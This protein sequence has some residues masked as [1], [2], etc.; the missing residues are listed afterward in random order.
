MGGKTSK[1]ELNKDLKKIG[2]EANRKNPDSLESGNVLIYLNELIAINSSSEPEKDYKIIKL[3]KK[4]KF[5]DINLV[6][7]KISG[8]KGIMKTLHKAKYFSDNDE[9]FLKALTS[10]DHPNIINIFSFY[11][12]ENSYS[13][14]TEL[15]SNG[16][17]Y[18]ELLNNGIYNE[19]TTA[20]IM[21]QIFSAVNYYHKRKI[22]N[23][24]LSLD[25]ILISEK[26]NNFPTIKISYFGSS[27]MAENNLIER[28]KLDIT[29]YIAPEIINK[30]YNEK[31]DIWSC[32]VIMY[33]LLLA[34]P[35]F[36][37]ETEDEINQKIL[38]GK[39]DIICSF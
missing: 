7:N 20:Y 33:L 26:R 29:F 34:R 17:L 35:P 24:G 12:N 5:S 3:I 36:G 13:Y 23:C 1:E 27:I 38:L 14:I 21:Y 4:G 31:C 10:L 16:D 22:I 25:N 37:G 39:Y 11:I 2:E 15:C 30:K 6:E 9:Q 28:N 18:Q 19:K 8:N 32:G